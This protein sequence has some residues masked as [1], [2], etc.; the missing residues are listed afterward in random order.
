MLP[1]LLYGPELENDSAPMEVP[2]IKWTEQSLPFLWD[3]RALTGDKDP[4]RARHRELQPGLARGPAFP[5]PNAHEPTLVVC[6]GNL[7][8]NPSNT[9]YWLGDIKQVASP[10][11]ACFLIW[12]TEMQ[13][14]KKS[15]QG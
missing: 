8:S 7:T 2:A 11:C 3:L 5:F 13:S 10:L 1:N 14:C 12:L 4:K 9:V 6:Q 15:V